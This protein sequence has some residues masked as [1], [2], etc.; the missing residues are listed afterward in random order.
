MACLHLGYP[1]DTTLEWNDNTESFYLSI[2]KRCIYDF[3]LT[4][5]NLE[6]SFSIP[7]PGGEGIERERK[8]VIN[9]LSMT[10][11]GSILISE[12]CKTKLSGQKNEF[13]GL[14]KEN[15]LK[16]FESVGCNVIQ[17]KRSS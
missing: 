8:V 5:R 9:S 7:F 16:A 13:I 1:K 4:D 14:T 15:V 12:S 10:G 6:F 3:E 11:I 17:K 2:E